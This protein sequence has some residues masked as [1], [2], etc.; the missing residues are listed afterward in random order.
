ML[1]LGGTAGSVVGRWGFADVCRHGGVEGSVEFPTAQYSL[2]PTPSAILVLMVGK[3]GLWPSCG[4]A[5]WS[6]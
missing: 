5:I 1:G 6:I 3:R 2:A 4:D